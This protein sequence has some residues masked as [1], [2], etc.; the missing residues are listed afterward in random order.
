MVESYEEIIEGISEKGYAIIDSFLIT[1]L[2]TDL[3]N[4]LLQLQHKKE[5][6]PAGIGQEKAYQTNTAVR[7]DQI[8]WLEEHTDISCESL[9][10]GLIRDFMSYLNRTC[11]TGLHTAEFHY[12]LYPI[13]AFYKK[14]VDQFRFDDKRKFSVITYLNE[15]WHDDDGGE[16]VLYLPDKTLKVLPYGGRLV[17]FESGKIEH[18]VLPAKRDRLSLT[19]WLKN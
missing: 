15:D 3:R 16:L 17:C 2:V 19:G 12:A 13:G 10:L 4:H 1:E 18:E 9:F 7:R 8:F 6:S 11:F 14:H 5:L